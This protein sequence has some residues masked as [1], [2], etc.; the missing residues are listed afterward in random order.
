MAAM[1]TTP[2]LSERDRGIRDG[3]LL[4]MHAISTISVTSEQDGC[5]HLSLFLVSF[6]EGLTRMIVEIDPSYADKRAV[7]VVW[8]DQVRAMCREA[9]G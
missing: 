9:L 7:F 8:L 2:E 3:L 4:A 6:G 5:P 1:T